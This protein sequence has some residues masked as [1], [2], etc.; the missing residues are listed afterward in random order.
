MFPVIE[1]PVKVIVIVNVGSVYYIMPHF[2]PNESEYS[3]LS[4]DPVIY[5]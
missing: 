3:K 2:G 4:S 5:S 1:V